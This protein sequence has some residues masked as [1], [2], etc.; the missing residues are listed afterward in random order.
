MSKELE[1]IDRQKHPAARLAAAAAMWLRAAPV[2]ERERDPAM[3]R[4][5]KE[6]LE[7][8]WR[9][10]GV[11]RMT[12]VM[13]GTTY[14]WDR[15]ELARILGIS[16]IQYNKAQLGRHPL[17]RIELEK[18]A[19]AKGLPLVKL[20]QVVLITHATMVGM[21]TGWEMK[22]QE[23][24]EP[25]SPRERRTKVV[26]D[27]SLHSWGL[28]ELVCT[29]SLE[30]EDPDEAV[31]LAELALLILEK[32]ELG[33]RFQR[34]LQGYA[35][36]HLGHALERRGDHAAAA[37]AY[38]ECIEIWTTGEGIME[39]EDRKQAERLASI[40]PSFPPYVPPPR[41]RKRAKRT[42]SPK[43]KP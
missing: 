35:W 19:A 7:E 29:K 24:L 6:A 33:A 15:R 9:Y 28:G 25:L 14:G 37:T 8:A 4:L 32:Q 21:D 20:Q 27:K 10:P 12:L 3:S 11:P 43:K 23:S 2:E 38:A 42:G 36:G 39:H 16:P 17:G 22:W 34:R 41:R 26:E 18:I 5:V 13:L 1:L 31:T 30:A 40:V